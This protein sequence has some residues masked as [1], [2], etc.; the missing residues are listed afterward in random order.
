MT[1]A[2]ICFAISLLSMVYM[3]THGGTSLGGA[4]F[5]VFLA[6][7]ILLNSLDEKEK[8]IKRLHWRNSPEGKQEEE[9][10]EKAHQKELA[11]TNPLSYDPFYGSSA[12][13]SEEQ[14]EKILK[15]A[16]DKKPT[17]L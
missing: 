15:K 7:A 10:W 6:F 17:N 5:Y 12:I 4:I 2:R 8:E 13:F 3:M 1:A 16:K 14:K 9:G 11:E